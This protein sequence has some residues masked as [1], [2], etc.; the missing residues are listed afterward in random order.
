MKKL[1]LIS[2]AILTVTVFS[3][4][5]KD[6]DDPIVYAGTWSGVYLG[7]DDHGTWA[8]TIDSN[9]DVTGAASSAVYIANFELIG[10]IDS[11]GTFNA[12]AGSASTGSEFVGEFNETTASGTW[13]NSNLGFEGTW[14]GARYDGTLE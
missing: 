8:V 10:T 11:E 2:L 13:S 6:S 5:K 7:D 14:S 9:G 4:K 1:L 12:T 3:C